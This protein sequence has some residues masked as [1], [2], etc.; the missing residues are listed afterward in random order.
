MKN[1][2]KIIGLLTVFCFVL[3]LGLAV[4]PAKEVSAID[5]AYTDSGDA[6]K[7]GRYKVNEVSEINHLPYGVVHYRHQGESTSDSIAAGS[8]VDGIYGPST[9]GFVKGQYYAQQ[10]NVL[11]VPSTPG[12]K[13]IPWMNYTGN[14]WNLT[15]VKTLLEILKLKTQSG[16]LLVVLTVMDLILIKSYHSQHNLMVLRLV[17]EISLN[18]QLQE[19]A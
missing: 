18:Q 2:K 8:D 1:I 17:M 5:T 13:L 15:T 11:E 4:M 16:Q 14:K 19:M 7:T 3:V 6:A 10:V 9:E 12:V